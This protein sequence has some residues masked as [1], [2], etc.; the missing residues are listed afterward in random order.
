MQKLFPVVL[1]LTCALFLLWAKLGASGTNPLP[2]ADIQHPLALDWEDT[3]VLTASGPSCTEWGGTREV[4]KVYLNFYQAQKDGL[5]Y[6][7]SNMAPRVAVW[8]RDTLCPQ[9]AERHLFLAGHKSLSLAE[10]AA[11]VQYMQQLLP[12]S[13]KSGIPSSGVPLSDGNRY[14]IR[15][16]AGTRKRLEFLVQDSKSEWNDFGPLRHRLFPKQ[17]VLDARQFITPPSPSAM[18]EE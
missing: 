15:L 14:Y 1:A 16:Y 10:E 9:G 2:T 13:L 7:Q 3:L 4:L 12:H 5:E 18:R 11:I 8:L 17:E 6:D